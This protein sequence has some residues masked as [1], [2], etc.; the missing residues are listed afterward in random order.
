MNKKIKI[1]ATIALALNFAAHGIAYAT[2]SDK[3]I[4]NKLTNNINAHD[5]ID[6]DVDVHVK[7]G[8]VTLRGEVDNKSE[9]ALAQR[10]AVNTPGVTSVKNL[11]VIDKD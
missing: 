5:D 6:H 3:V 10:L 8:V 1:L 7:D 4:K 2:N 11:L 9:K